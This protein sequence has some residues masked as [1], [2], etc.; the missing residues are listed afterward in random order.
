MIIDIIIVFAYLITLLVIGILQ[1]SK[2]SNFKGFSKIDGKITKSKLMLVATI[3]ASSV[4]GGATFG[5]SEKV[6]AGDASYSYG[7]ILAIAIDILI[8]IYIIPR[9]VRHHGAES[10][11]DIMHVYYGNTGRYIAGVSAILVSIGLVAAQISV[12]GRIFEYILQIDYVFGV[13]LS[14]GIIIVYTTIGGFRSVLFTNQLQFFAMVISI[15]IISIFG[16]YQIGL[17]EFINAVPLEKISFSSNP[18]LLENTISATL[19]FAVINLLPTFLQRALISKDSASTSWA[20]YIKSFI[21]ALFVI[22]IT[23]NGLVAF[24]KYPE[25]KASLALPYLIDHIIPTGIQ[26]LV[27]V[28][29]LAAVTSTADSDL[30]ITSVTLVKDFLSPVMKIKNQTTMLN[31]ARII[32]IIIGSLAIL[33]AL[34]FSM[35][36]DLVIFIVGFWGPVLI[37]PLVLALFDITISKNGFVLSCLTG[38]VTFLAW[39]KFYAADYNLKGVFVGTMANLVVFVVFY[40]CCK[41]RHKIS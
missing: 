23:L 7:L 18:N 1:K 33:I 11:G 34:R 4:G 12:S 17:T 22:F 20:I 29:L 32:N 31:L 9:L 13:V 40:F 3:F 8:A 2:K 21:Y 14:Y 35:V 15:P 37:P 39:E 41:S 19:G 25:I 5:I 16:I 27:V 6:F 30:N 24:V 36:L 28:G 26:G 38:I 10:V